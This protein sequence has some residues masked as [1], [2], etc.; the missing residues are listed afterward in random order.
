MAHINLKKI[1]QQDVLSLIDEIQHV[2][3]LT[4]VIQDPDGT[5]LMGDESYNGERKYAIEVAGQVIGWVIGGQEITPIVS[6]LT[7]LAKQDLEKKTLAQQVLDGYREI[8]IIG[9]IAQKL[10]T[11]LDVEAIALLALQEAQNLIRPTR[12]TLLLL[13]EPTG[14]WKTW[15][16]NS[17]EDRLE[18]T[19]QF[20]Q[21]IIDHVFNTGNAEIVNDVSSDPRWVV[22]D[23]PVYSLICAPLKS[24]EQV[25]GIIYLTHELPISYTATDLKQLVAIASQVAPAVEK[26]RL[27]E[28]FYK[29]KEEQAQTLELKLEE[30]T[31]QLQIEIRDRIAAEEAL[32]TSVREATRSAAE[33][34]ALFAAMSELI[35][36]YDSQGRCLKIAP[37]NPAILYK[38]ADE[39][40]GN[41]LHEIFEQSQA[42]TF[43]G[44]I[45]QALT[46]KQTVNF[47]YNVIIGKR[48]V[49]FAGSISPISEDSVI[50]VGRDITERKQAEKALWEK[51]QVLNNVP[52]QIFWKDTNLV[53]Q[54][55]NKNWAKSAQLES[56]EAVVGLT[57]YDLLAN[58]EIA[59]QYRA[60]DRHVMETDTPESHVVES[61]Q[62]TGLDGEAIWLDVSRVPIHDE[63]GNVIGIL[64]TLEDITLRKRA[65]EALLESQRQL[66]N[67]NVVLVEL[68]RKKVLYQGDLKAALKEITEA[69]VRT[70]E[71]ERASVWL[72][73]KTALKLQCIDLFEQRVNQHSEGIELAAK[74]YPSYFKALA[75]D[76]TIAAH[77]AYNDPR[78]REF[79]ES[80]LT[81][82]GI[83][84]MLDTPIRL[85]GRTVGT[86]CLEQVGLARHWT[87]EDQN[88]AGSLADLVSLAIEA[89]RRKRA[90]IALQQAEEKYRSI[91]ENAAEGICQTSPD[92]YYLSVNP[93]LAR[94]YGYLSPEELIA[95]LTN[96]AQ[97]LYVNP[98]RRS[99]FIAAMEQHETVS[100]FES[101]VY[102][103]DG[104]I[105]WVSE[106][107][108]A[109]KDVDGRLLYYEGTVQNITLRKETELAL[110]AEQEKSERLLLNVLPKAIADQLKQFQGSLAEQ[111][112]EA[113][114]MFADIVGF[115]PLSA[116]M[117][118]IEL[119]SMLNQIFSTFD[120]LAE[121]HGLEKIK[122]IGDAYMVAGGLPRIQPAHAEAIAEMALD[123]QRE[124]KRFHRDDGEPFRLRIGIN[125][126]PVVAGV[127][128]LRKFIYDL[129]GDTV[130]VA[131]RME[132][133]GVAGGIQVTAATYQHLKDKYL[134]EERGVTFVKGKGEMTTYWLT[135]RL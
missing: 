45:Q 37:T 97:Q 35:I 68:A 40:I 106:N 9:D 4:V 72:Y 127:I 36:V 112:D 60:R 33:M 29:V 135:G 28:A 77:D 19:V 52:Q 102:R 128:G 17:T 31:Q 34:R 12:G 25:I 124:I 38:P 39:M 134:F 46:T 86:L 92:G 117:R 83:N 16:T 76:W 115:T 48:D 47:E 23:Y 107:A 94:M 57:D 24:N 27:Y 110:R 113:T 78:T 2:A 6:L 108:R 44:Y 120:Q 13:E 20:P 14:T 71:I 66:R 49:W 118:P 125:T 58:R 56:P 121:Q 65:E 64:G 41:T 133:Q 63:R 75:E 21:G 54:G 131:S 98:N 95:N 55:C 62:K 122:T 53:F 18:A 109:V 99:E 130:N 69:A 129:W 114:I 79:S 90:E 73:D 103:Q 105:I 11:C 116:R 84:S 96:I 91:F 93:A 81:P 119:V 82:L 80:Y 61:K 51:E 59:E 1:L 67:Q 43:L 50:W 123:M 30:R 70:L 89:Q 10:A 32:S 3:G 104:S 22:S 74:D 111:F 87:L 7:C 15:T 8:N 132:S 88:F 101:Q 42:D 26:T 100:N 126:G 5:I 85:G